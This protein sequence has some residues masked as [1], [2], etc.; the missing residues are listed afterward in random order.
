MDDSGELEPPPLFG[1]WRRAY[2]FV[3][4]HLGLLIAA[5]WAFSRVFS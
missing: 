5:F 1:S 2:V 3:I 4:V